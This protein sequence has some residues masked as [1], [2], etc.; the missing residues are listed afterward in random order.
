[1]TA[2]VSIMMVTY[3]RLELTKQT[4]EN[5]YNTVNVPFNFIIIDNAST[6]GTIKYLNGL[7]VD[8][9]NVY[10]KYNNENKGISCG[11][12]Q[13]L[14]IANKLNTEWYVTI[15]N[16]VLF[17]DGWLNECI[18]ILKANKNFGAIG[19]SFED[20]VYPLV[21]LNGHEFEYKAKG[22]LGT[23]CMVF[24]KSLHKMIGFFS[25]EY[26]KFYGLEDSSFGN[27]IIFSGLKLGYIKTHGQHLGV[28]EA[29]TGKYREFKTTEH[30]KHLKQYYAD[31]GLYASGKKS[32][33]IPF[34]ESE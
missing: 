24:H 21:K 7:N 17:H 22:N 34:K 9:D 15:D 25:M 4:V 10:I 16:D 32:L 13:S 23:A 2:T 19:V 26:S 8:K 14:V 30:N 28:G 12:N 5:I 31:Y 6:D 3:N 29:D 20:K 18:D 1:M 11:R 33:Y 27:R